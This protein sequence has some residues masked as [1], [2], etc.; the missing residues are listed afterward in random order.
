VGRAAQVQ[1]LLTAVLAAV[2]DDGG[3]VIVGG[4]IGVG[5]TRLVERV[6]GLATEVGMGVRW[7]NCWRDDG[8]PPLWPWIQL[9]RAAGPEGDEAGAAR[10]LDFG[11]PGVRLF[12]QVVTS[13]RD[14]AE[15]RP[16]LLVLDDLHWA[17]AASLRLLRFM[18]RELRGSRL[19]VIGTYREADAALADLLEGAGGSRDHLRLRGLS[20][21]E[22][23]ELVEALT[24]RAPEPGE[25]AALHRRTGG[26][27][28]LVRELTLG[29]EEPAGGEVVRLDV[30]HG[31]GRGLSPRQ[32]EV[33]RLV[34]DGLGNEEIAER[35]SIS[36]R[37]VETHVDHVR[38]RLSLDT[39]AA[40]VSWV[41]RQRTGAP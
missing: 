40:I 1:A 39:R 21:V 7:A 2:H 20:P 4:E 28:L 6:A 16:L 38:R 33:A 17:D 29:S 18:A 12:D 25:L 8:A 35:L 5:K 31:G 14:A 11:E 37:T 3:L 24:L 10:P 13:L 26:N 22:T 23:A 15:R 32:W 30:E 41:V 34:A 27:P 36:R 19:L 9:L